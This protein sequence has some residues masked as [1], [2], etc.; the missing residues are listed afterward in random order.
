MPS[1]AIGCRV[2]LARRTGACANALNQTIFVIRR[3]SV[4]VAGAERH[5]IA[6]RRAWRTDVGDFERWRTRRSTCGGALHGPFLDKFHVP[7]AGELER[8]VERAIGASTKIRSGFEQLAS[9]S[10]SRMGERQ[11]W[12]VQWRRGTG[13]CAVHVRIDARAGIGR[14][15]WRHRRGP[16][17]RAACPIRLKSGDPRI[18][19]FVA[20]FA[21]ATRPL[22]QLR[23]FRPATESADGASGE[24][25]IERCSGTDLHA[26]A[27]RPTT[28][29][30]NAEHERSMRRRTKPGQFA[31]RAVWRRKLKQVRLKESD[32]VIH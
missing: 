20:D 30:P 3:T 24:R 19:A 11:P 21:I 2:A 32:P 31:V 22:A 9:T 13:D 6:R 4:P 26:G 17:L 18:S 7:D 29:T 15:G 27:F 28:N 5:E 14:R 16:G 23:A 25:L 1:A 8:W 12:V 10:E